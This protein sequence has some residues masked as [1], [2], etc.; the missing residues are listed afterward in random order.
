M[1]YAVAVVAQSCFFTSNLT[2]HEE[3]LTVLNLIFDWL[4]FYQKK[5]LICN[6][7]AATSMKNNRTHIFNQHTYTFFQLFFMFLAYQTNK[8]DKSKI[9]LFL[10]MLLKRVK[11]KNKLFAG[12]YHIYLFRGNPFT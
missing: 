2:E 1:L 9:K 8:E 4:H 12:T 10:L 7:D 3:Y 5:I 6:I 11:N